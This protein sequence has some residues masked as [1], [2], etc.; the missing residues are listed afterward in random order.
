MSETCLP[1]PPTKLDNNEPYVFSFYED[2]VQV[3]SIVSSLNHFFRVLLA[4]SPRLNYRRTSLLSTSNLTKYLSSFS[5]CIS[6]C[7]VPKSR[8]LLP[9]LLFSIHRQYRFCFVPKDYPRL[10]EKKLNEIKTLLRTLGKKSR[11]GCRRGRHKSLCERN[12]K[13]ELMQKE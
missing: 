7:F 13:P 6:R 2:I 11:N 12:K 1:C 5:S 8:F 9:S 4:E 3:S 10:L